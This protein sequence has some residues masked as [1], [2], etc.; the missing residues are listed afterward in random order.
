M[1]VNR[2]SPYAFNPKITLFTGVKERYDGETLFVRKSYEVGRGS[3]VPASEKKLYAV[4]HNLVCTCK[5]SL[6]LLLIRQPSYD[7]L[8]RGLDFEGN[9]KIRK[10][11]LSALDFEPMPRGTPDI[12][13]HFGAGLTQSW[14]AK[15]QDALQPTVAFSEYLDNVCITLSASTI[16]TF[17]LKACLEEELSM[18]RDVNKRVLRRSTDAGDTALLQKVK[19]L[20]SSASGRS[21]I[22]DYRSPSDRLASKLA[23]GAEMVKVSEKVQQRSAQASGRAVARRELEAAKRAAAREGRR[24]GTSPFPPAASK[25]KSKRKSKVGAA[26]VPSGYELK[27]AGAIE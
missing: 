27:S 12:E 24:E 9:E 14:L 11:D 17:C 25:K 2:S 15:L 20:Q 7:S 10:V 16:R 6:H 4:R 1:K 23:V 3:G 21:A 19:H 22:A 18:H 13:L 8:T 5:L 26:N